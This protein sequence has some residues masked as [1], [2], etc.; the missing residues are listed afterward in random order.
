MEVYRR[1]LYIPEV[2]VDFLF[3][4]RREGGIVSISFSFTSKT[5]DGNIPKGPIRI[6]MMSSFLSY[7]SSFSH[8]DAN[9]NLPSTRWASIL[10]PDGRNTNLPQPSVRLP[11]VRERAL[12]TSCGVRATDSSDVLTTTSPPAPGECA[13]I[14]LFSFLGA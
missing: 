2:S 13:C 9:W 3:P 4:F 6:L 11:T 5:N 14:Y 8:V 1:Y 12:T 7:F 10:L